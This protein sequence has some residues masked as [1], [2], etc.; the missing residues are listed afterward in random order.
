MAQTSEVLAEALEMPDSRLPKS[1]LKI[2]PRLALV[3][4]SRKGYPVV[5]GWF[6]SSA[7]PQFSARKPQNQHWHPKPEPNFPNPVLGRVNPEAAELDAERA[8]I[9]LCRVGLRRH[10][11]VAAEAQQH[12]AGRGVGV[13]TRVDR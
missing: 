12:R 13:D 11:G 10:P 1:Y 2:A 4:H 7:V 5:I 6:C 9:D 3:Q 8:P